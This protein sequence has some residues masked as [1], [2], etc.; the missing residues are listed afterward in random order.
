L[1]Q[2]STSATAAV[3]GSLEAAGCVLYRS[4]SNVRQAGAWVAQIDAAYLRLEAARRQGDAKAANALIAPG[5]RFVVTASSLTVG[6]VFSGEELRSLLSGIDAGPAGN[7][8]RNEFG[9]QL[10]CDLD[11]AWVRRQYAPGR[12]PP[13]HA[14]HGWHQDGALGFDFLSHRGG[15]FPLDALL[16]MVTCWIALG[17]CGA[18]APGL[19]LV[20]HRLEGLLAP[21]DLTD[22][23]V[24]SR[25]R[26][27]A[28]WRPVME[29]GDALLFH[30]DIL[31][32]THV[33]P[34]MTRD[35]TSVEL[36]Y[37]PAAAIPPRLKSDRFLLPD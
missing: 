9:K 28:F 32:R 7:W 11:Q 3:Q 17:P 31:H 16:S 6:A 33:T 5:E 23:C 24:R 21:T 4:L 8:M 36:R 2:A 19:E 1:N 15:E 22:A 25:F 29:A 27:E 26:P 10:A 13:G 30:G 35:R 14:P 34:A 18:D 37:F 20:N 12:Y